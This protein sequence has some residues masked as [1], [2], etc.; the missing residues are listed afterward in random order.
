[1][2]YATNFCKFANFKIFDVLMVDFSKEIVR[3]LGLA[4]PHG[5]SLSELFS[6]LD[7]LHQDLR[8][9]EFFYTNMRK[10]KLGLIFTG[11]ATQELHTLS[12]EL[13]LKNN[14]YRFTVSDVQRERAV[15]GSFYKSQSFPDATFLIL[16][17]IAKSKAL[18]M[19]QVELA[20]A[21]GQDARTVFHHLKILGTAK[22]IVKY[23]II[24]DKVT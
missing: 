23:P 21:S 15:M 6:N 11:N 22:V 17:L 5:L 8:Y 19:T 12:C 3:E 20:K 13:L 1:V 9:Q 2:F 7:I 4:G 16:S 18:G 14:H 10:L 24:H